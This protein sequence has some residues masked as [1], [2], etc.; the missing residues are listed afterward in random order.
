MNVP[1]RVQSAYEVL[2]LKRQRLVAY[3]ENPSNQFQNSNYPRSQQQWQGS[4]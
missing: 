1:V 2:E 4:D 3:N